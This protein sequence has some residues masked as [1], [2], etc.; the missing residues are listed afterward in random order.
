MIKISIR[1]PNEDVK[2]TTGYR[3]LGFQR[4]FKARETDLG[5]TDIQITFDT[6]AVDEGTK[7]NVQTRRRPRTED[8]DPSSN[9]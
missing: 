5:I 6:M 4:E 7:G 8:W 9:I 3:N 2:E 1:Y